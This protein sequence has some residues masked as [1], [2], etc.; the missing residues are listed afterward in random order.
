MEIEYTKTA[1]HY[2]FKL[3]SIDPSSGLS[4]ILL[5]I[6]VAQGAATLSAVKAGGWKGLLPAKVPHRQK[7]PM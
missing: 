5:C 1:S 4:N 3:N 2:F 7:F 6:L